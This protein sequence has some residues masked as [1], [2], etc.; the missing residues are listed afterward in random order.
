MT[1]RPVPRVVVR[2]YFGETKTG[3]S[4]FPMFGRCGSSE[5]MMQKDQPIFRISS[6]GEE[7]TGKKETLLHFSGQLIN[8]IQGLPRLEHGIN[9]ADSQQ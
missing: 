7:Q 8:L 4:T 1:A 5:L 9:A 6:R 2:T 3:P